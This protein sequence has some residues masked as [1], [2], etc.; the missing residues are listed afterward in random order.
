MHF[1]LYY[2]ETDEVRGKCGDNM[3]QRVKAECKFRLLQLGLSFGGTHTLPDELL[4]N[5][6][7]HLIKVLLEDC[8]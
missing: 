2:I 6:L 8:H 1:D 3:Q 5:V 7:S 4:V